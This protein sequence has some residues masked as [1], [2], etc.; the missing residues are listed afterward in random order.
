MFTIGAL[1]H[2]FHLAFEDVQQIKVYCSQEERRT[3]GPLDPLRPGDEVC[4]IHRR[5]SLLGRPVPGPGN[6][7]LQWAA[8]AVGSGS[9]YEV[10]KDW[11]AQLMEPSAA[12]GHIQSSSLQALTT[13]QLAA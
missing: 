7:W 10:G 5:R 13:I 2:A 3:A 12:Y 9:I 1:E 4:L 11:P 6:F 8:Y